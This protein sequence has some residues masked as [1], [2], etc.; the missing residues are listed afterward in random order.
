MTQMTFID[1]NMIAGHGQIVTYW[2]KGLFKFVF[3]A[4]HSILFNLSPNGR[5]NKFIEVPKA[6]NAE[7]RS[8]IW[9]REVKQCLESSISGTI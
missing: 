7:L 3:V 1:V 9:P 6:L 2:N 5:D 4:Y 8:T